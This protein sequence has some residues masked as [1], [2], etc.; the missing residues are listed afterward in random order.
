M[1]LPIMK[2]LKLVEFA[3]SLV[4]FARKLP[5]SDW[6]SV[7]SRFQQTFPI[8]FVILIKNYCNLYMI[9]SFG[10]IEKNME[11]LQDHKER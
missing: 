11:V 2:N 8:F 5:R 1:E 3:S 4:L 7:Q 6:K 9:H 10:R